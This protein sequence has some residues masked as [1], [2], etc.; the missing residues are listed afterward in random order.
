MAEDNSHPHTNAAVKAKEH[1]SWKFLDKS[2]CGGRR[3]RALDVE[4]I[5]STRQCNKQYRVQKPIGDNTNRC[6]RTVILI[7]H[8]AKT[9][10]LSYV[11]YSLTHSSQFFNQVA[12]VAVLYNSRTS[13]LYGTAVQR[14]I[15]QQTHYYHMSLI[16]GLL[17]LQIESFLFQLD[18]IGYFRAQTLGF[19]KLAA[20]SPGCWRHC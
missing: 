13:H 10:P 9:K 3:P 4:N 14:R 16:I 20:A 8:S 6:S 2:W 1:Y 5:Q 15:S 19:Q 18:I 11:A 7:G 17:L 12:H